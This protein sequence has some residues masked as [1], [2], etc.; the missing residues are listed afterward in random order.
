M[1][2]HLAWKPEGSSA[3]CFFLQFLPTQQDNLQTQRAGL[4]SAGQRTMLTSLGSSVSGV[5]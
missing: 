2:L 4:L 1:A 3:L 5:S